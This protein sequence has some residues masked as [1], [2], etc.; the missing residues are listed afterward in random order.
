MRVSLFFDG[1][2]Y[3]RALRDYDQCAFPRTLTEVAL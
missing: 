3:Y 1:N 2:N